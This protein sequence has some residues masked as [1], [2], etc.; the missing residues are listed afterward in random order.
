MKK[1]GGRV[2]SGAIGEKAGKEKGE[3]GE[4]EKEGKKGRNGRSLGKMEQWIFSSS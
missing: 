2:W 4:G 3:E 1:G